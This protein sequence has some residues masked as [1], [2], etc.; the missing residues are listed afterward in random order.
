MS[1]ST[2]TSNPITTYQWIWDKNKNPL[3]FGFRKLTP[4]ENEYTIRLRA[5][6]SQL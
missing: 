6:I 4:T 1:K 5:G 2:I 3:D